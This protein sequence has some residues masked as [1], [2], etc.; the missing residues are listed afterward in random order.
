MSAALQKRATDPYRVRAFWDAEAAV[1]VATSDDVPGL[2]AEAPT[3]E[4][5]VDDLRAI[6]PELLELNHVPRQSRIEVALVAERNEAIE[7]AG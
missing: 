6:V 2:V 1:W 4:A 7:P 3:I 5:L